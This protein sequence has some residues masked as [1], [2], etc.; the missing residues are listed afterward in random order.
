MVETSIVVFLVNILT[1]ALRKWAFP[2]WGRLGVQIIAFVLALIG[3]LYMTY[4][5]GFPSLVVWVKEGLKVLALSI[6]FYDI[7]LKNIPV[8]RK[9]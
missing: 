5:G 6:A 1:S 2:K 7:V 8:F 4:S 3:A 9:S